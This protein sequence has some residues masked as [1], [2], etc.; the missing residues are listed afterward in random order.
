[1]D[2]RNDLK[3]L[4]Q[5][6]CIAKQGPNVGAQAELLTHSHDSLLPVKPW[7][8]LWAERGAQAGK[9]NTASHR[10]KYCNRAGEILLVA[11]SGDYG[12]DPEQDKQGLWEAAPLE[13]AGHDQRGAASVSGQEQEEQKP[14]GALSSRLVGQRRRELV[15]HLVDQHAGV[16]DLQRGRGHPAQGVEHDVNRLWVQP[17]G[18]G[19]LPL[20]HTLVGDSDRPHSLEPAGPKTTSACVF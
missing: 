1:M 10:E 18:V 4:R 20:L 12:R 13:A 2:F 5:C 6:H 15:Q 7:P 8:G 14:G 16:Q 3:V 17:D 9:G 11:A 19:R